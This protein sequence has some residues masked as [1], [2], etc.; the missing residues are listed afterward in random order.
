MNK[1]G[2]RGTIGFGLLMVFI[3]VIFALFAMIG[4]WKETFDTARGDSALNCPGTPG[5]NQS[6]F[7][8]D[9]KF[10]KLNKR[11]PCFITGISM[12]WF[13]GAVLLG[14]ISWLFR[15]WRGVK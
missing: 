3:L 2:G 8:D 9:D 14:T 6:D 1:R 5:F 11:G 12:I 10:D 7:D 13:L 4:P 15:N